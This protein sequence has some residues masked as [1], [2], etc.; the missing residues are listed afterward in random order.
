MKKFDAFLNKLK[1]EITNIKLDYYRLAMEC[2][3]KTFGKFSLHY[4]PSRRYS[5]SSYELMI[6]TAKPLRPGEMIVLNPNSEVGQKIFVKRLKNWMKKKIYRHSI[7]E[8]DLLKKDV[9]SFKE[10]IFKREKIVQQLNRICSL[11]YIETKK[12]VNK[13]R[14]GKNGT[15]GLLVKF[16]G[17]KNF[18]RI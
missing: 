14:W 2:E 15:S 1:E 6:P 18:V 17:K 10:E 7:E 5:P 12:D 16:T 4:G 11:V 8:K 9:L 3:T 13:K